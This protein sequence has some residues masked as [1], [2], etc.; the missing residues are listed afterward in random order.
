[1]AYTETQFRL[2]V[3]DDGKGIDPHERIRAERTGHWGQNG[4]RERA[5]RVGG[6]LEVWSESG[7]GTGIESKVP[8][9]I[10][11]E[12]VVAPRWSR[13]TKRWP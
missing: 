12:T 5:E 8:A 6:E 9:S 1:M 7:A 3:R 2:L 10:T 4:M 11:Y 13:A